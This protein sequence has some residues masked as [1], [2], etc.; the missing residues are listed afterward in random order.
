VLQ[1]PTV[2]ISRCREGGEAARLEDALARLCTARGWDVQVVPDL[3]HLPADSPL[4]LELAGLGLAVPVACSMHPRPAAQLLRDCGLEAEVVVDL[5][6][7]ADAREALDAL[8]LPGVAGAG[9][10]RELPAAGGERWYP[11]IDRGRC[12]GCRAC[13]QFCLFGVYELDADGQVLVVRPDNC[14]PGCPAC[15]RICPEGAIIFPLCDEP[16]IA[17]APGTLMQP[18][19]AA[20]RMY[21]VRSGRPCP[22]CGGVAT[23]GDAPQEGAPACA[24]CGRALPDATEPSQVHDEIDAL[25]DMLDGLAGGGAR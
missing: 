9:A 21:Y 20:R 12:A 23:A 24:E 15:S 8:A 7:C 3:Y 5:R 18:D 6:T 10:V 25:I 14:K 2:I 22:V 11:V 1:R 17:G 19:P 4:R 16:A 13:L